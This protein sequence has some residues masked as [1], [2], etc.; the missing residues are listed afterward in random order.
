[1]QQTKRQQPRATVAQRVQPQTS[2]TKNI[3]INIDFDGE[4]DPVR[5]GGQIKFEKFGQSVGSNTQ[6]L[7]L[8]SW[9]FGRKATVETLSS[10][11]HRIHIAVQKDNLNLVKDFKSIETNFSRISDKQAGIEKRLVNIGKFI[12]HDAREMDRFKETV[13]EEIRR[14]EGMNELPKQTNV[15]Q[16]TRTQPEKKEKTGGGSWLSTLAL[17]GGGAVVGKLLWDQYGDQIKTFLWNLAKKEWNKRV[18]EQDKWLENWKNRSN[19]EVYEQWQKTFKN[20]RDSLKSLGVIIPDTS[21]ADRQRFGKYIDQNNQI[22][23]DI[24]DWRRQQQQKA[25]G[26]VG[27]EGKK[28]GPSRITLPMK[29]IADQ[30]ERD[31]LQQQN[32]VDQ[33]DLPWRYKRMQAGGPK[34]TV[35][36]RGLEHL[37]LSEKTGY[38]GIGVMPR[39]TDTFRQMD[40][41]EDEIRYNEKLRRTGHTSLPHITDTKK[42]QVQPMHLGMRPS[43]FGEFGRQKLVTNRAGVSQKFEEQYHRMQIEK[44]KSQFLQFGKLPTP[45]FEF[46][47]GHMGLLGTEGAHRAR[48]AVGGGPRM[49]NM[50]GTGTAGRT[51]FSRGYGSGGGTSGGSVG[52]TSGGSVGGIPGSY[53]SAPEN[54]QN[55]ESLKEIR[56]AQAK[57]M[58]DPKIKS[59]VFSRMEI[60]VGSQGP[61]AQQAWLESLYNRAASRRLSLYDAVSNTNKH[62]YY[63]LKDDSRWSR[64]T[65][66]GSKKLNEKYTTINDSV[67]G[68]SNISKFATGNASAMVGFGQGP[69]KR[70]GNKIV[71][72]GQTA[73]FGGERFGVEAPDKKWAARMTDLAKQESF[74]VQQTPDMNV[75]K[76]NLGG[77]GQQGQQFSFADATMI[78]GESSG[79]EYSKGVKGWHSSVKMLNN[80]DPLLRESVMQGAIEAFGDPRDPKTRYEIRINNAMRRG[81]LGASKHNIGKAT[82]LQIY[83]RETGKF[84]GGASGKNSIFH[85]AYGNPHTYKIYQSLARGAYKH[86]YTKYGKKVA[87]RQSWGGNFFA[88]QGMIGGAKVYG[89]FKTR[90]GMSSYDQMHLSLDEG[91]RQGMITR[92][93]GGRIASHLRK[94]GITPAG[95]MGDPTLW[96]SQYKQ[97]IDPTAVQSTVTTSTQNMDAGTRAADATTP[98]PMPDHVTRQFSDLDSRVQ[99]LEPKDM[100]TFADAK[101]A[102]TAAAVGVPTEALPKAKMEKKPMPIEHANELDIGAEREVSV[103]SAK[104]ETPM[105]DAA[106]AAEGAVDKEAAERVSP[107]VAPKIDSGGEKDSSS[108][109]TGGGTSEPSFRNRF[110][111]ERPTSTSDGYGSY[112]RCFV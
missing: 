85:N 39:D 6:K 13:I 26:A 87:D 48:G 37:M 111:S 78:G 104:V 93:A 18:D 79:K 25:K 65:R 1:M 68:G 44:D 101:K 112:G 108:S 80:V 35:N 40:R 51:V 71:A 60:E 53:G 28:T 36:T 42:L 97:Q 84:V 95:P 50:P 45:G 54:L 10:D 100:P 58:Q 21:D 43:M 5:K 52:G 49:F 73:D 30:K 64:M 89:G 23:K 109:S 4:I 56:A 11:L 8:E 70:I 106:K 110:E 16:V 14:Q 19:K 20:I 38:P 96:Q 7:N 62:R 33:K 61:K 9:G 34:S 86:L 107:V 103:D 82:D 59:A 66:Q 47:P 88:R 67:I 32:D 90:R 41:E 94:H 31:R 55:L 17:L 24:Q 98:A 15:P 77:P 63:P 74:K 76:M 105:M 72:P 81:P 69:A 46:L 91:G 75:G 92:G 27:K 99:K 57:E 22:N 2:I 102:D 3:N 83:D 12:K 29:D